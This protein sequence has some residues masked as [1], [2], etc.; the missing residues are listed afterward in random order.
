MKNILLLIKFDGYCCH[1][2]ILLSPHLFLLYIGPPLCNVTYCD[3]DRDN[4]DY[5]QVLCEPL[6]I[7]R[8]GLS[9]LTSFDRKEYR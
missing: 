1:S 8:R 6:G 9:V 4:L 5:E 7:K 3:D 2:T